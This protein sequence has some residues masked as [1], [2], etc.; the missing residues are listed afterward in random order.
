MQARRAPCWSRT[1]LSPASR[2]RRRTKFAR[3]CSARRC[4]SQRKATSRRRFDLRDIDGKPLHVATLSGPPLR[5]AVSGT[6]VRLLP[7][8]AEGPEILGAHPLQ[9]GARPGGLISTGSPE[10]NREQRFR[11]RVLLDRDFGGGRVFGATGTPSAVMLDAQGTIAS[12]VGVEPQPSAMLGVA[13]DAVRGRQRPAASGSAASFSNSQDDDW[14]ARRNHIDVLAHE[15][16]K[17]ICRAILA[18][19]VGGSAIDRHVEFQS[20]DV[21]EPAQSCG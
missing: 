7:G 2:R 15:F 14:C 11:S 12:D 10:A 1:A 9:G 3:S 5:R 20:P 6:V 21:P 13:V 18:L 19:E 4:R 8:D 17:R 16:D